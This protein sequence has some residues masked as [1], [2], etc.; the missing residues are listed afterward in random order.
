MGLNWRQ[1]FWYAPEK[2]I[3]GLHGTSGYLFRF[4]PRAEKVE[5]IERLT[6]QASR[7]SGMRDSFAY[8]YLGFALGPDGHTVY[9]LT[10]GPVP[11]GQPREE[12]RLVTYDIPA[13]QYQ[14]RGAVFLPDGQRPSGVQSI[15]AA[16]D[17]SVYALATF[18]RNGK[19]TA[20]L[21]HIVL[22]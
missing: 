20:D 18:T 4:D 2:A 14:D 22:K 1:T 19:R 16:R 12:L 8:G 17:G 5:V 21:I 11:G 13:A 7:R 6:S 10:T 15:A 3:Y 9:Y